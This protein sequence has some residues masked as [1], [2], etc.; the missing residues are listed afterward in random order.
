[1]LLHSV[2]KSLGEF[3]KTWKIGTAQ[4]IKAGVGTYRTYLICDTILSLF[5]GTY[6]FLFKKRSE[7]VESRHSTWFGVMKQN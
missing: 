4:L 5:F 3:K 6:V 1:M 2:M 7:E